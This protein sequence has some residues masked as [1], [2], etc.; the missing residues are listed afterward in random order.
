LY[1]STKTELW[2]LFLAVNELPP[3]Q[4]FARENMIV[5]GILQGKGKPPFKAFL[6]AFTEDMNA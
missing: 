5:A 6:N 4:R 2:P 3:T 1:S